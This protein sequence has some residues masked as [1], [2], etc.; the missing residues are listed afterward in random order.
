MTTAQDNGEQ[1]RRDW[2]ALLKCTLLRLEDDALFI[3]I[4]EALAGK[5]LSQAY[6]TLRDALAEAGNGQGE[7]LKKCPI[8]QE[9][10]SVC[11]CKLT[12]FLDPN[13]AHPVNPLAYRRTEP[14]EAMAGAVPC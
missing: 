2:A 9:D 5:Q 7:D 11:G 3:P 14:Q 12:Y 6:G 8:V 10:G 4:H 13:N 1:L